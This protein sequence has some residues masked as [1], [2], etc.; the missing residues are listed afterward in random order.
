MI[1]TGRLIW[2]HFTKTGGTFVRQLLKS[3]KPSRWWESPHS[4]GTHCGVTRIPA[5]EG[6]RLPIFSHVR[7]PWSWYASMFLFF[8]LPERRKAFFRIGHDSFKDWLHKELFTKRGFNTHYDIQYERM[9]AGGWGL[10]TEIFRHTFFWDGAEIPITFLRQETLRADLIERMPIRHEQKVW[11]MKHEDV[12]VPE[13]EKGLSY[14]D[15]FDDES[16]EWVAEREKFIIDR[17]GYEF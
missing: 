13:G 14:Q 17:F 4:W 3:D 2:L 5:R 7:N 11:V 9:R 8:G 12:N 1:I 6:K 16:R 15:C 10:Y